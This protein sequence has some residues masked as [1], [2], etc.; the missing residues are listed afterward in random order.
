MAQ[1]DR[2]KSRIAI[3]TAA[4]ARCGCTIKEIFARAKQGLRDVAINLNKIPE[5]VVRY[6]RR[7]LKQHFAERA[8]KKRRQQ[9]FRGAPFM[10]AC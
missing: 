9:Y 5:R 4:A 8:G 1:I 3:V 6:A 7:I 10:R 2:R